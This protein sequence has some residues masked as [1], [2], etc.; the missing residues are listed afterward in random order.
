MKSR[1]EFNVK[2][3]EYIQF[4]PVKKLDWKY[5][6]IIPEERAFFGLTKTRKAFCDGWSINGNPL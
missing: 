5:Y 3:I 4:K 1:I 2:D 6:D